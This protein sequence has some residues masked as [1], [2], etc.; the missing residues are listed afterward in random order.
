MPLISRLSHR[1]TAIPDK[2][3]TIRQTANEYGNGFRSYLLLVYY[4]LFRFNTFIV[5]EKNLSQALIKQNLGPYLKIIKPTLADLNNLRRDKNYPREFYCDQA[6]GAK[7]CYV[8]FCNNEVVS[9]HWVFTHGEYSR[10]LKLEETDVELNYIF[11][12]PHFRRQGISSKTIGYISMDLKQTGYKRLFAVVHENNI[13]SIHTIANAGF[14]E[15][16][17]IKAIGH[18][19][20]RVKL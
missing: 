7:T 17:R 9:I 2:I 19:H 12:M 14:I 6:K 11:T 20:K 1:L 15:S 5:F 8:G 4:S 13:A 3:R 10:F 18:I 16:F